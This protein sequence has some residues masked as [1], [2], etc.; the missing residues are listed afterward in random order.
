MITSLEHED[1]VI[2]YP[3]DLKQHITN[4]Y[5]KLIGYEN[6]ADIH[7]RE[8]IWSVEEKV[9]TTENERLARLFTIEEVDVALKQ[10]KNGTAPSPD[11][12]SIEFFKQF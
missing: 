6:T 8:E 2:A 10:I 5:K 3:D 9:N 12:L 7:L 1:R 4:Y 11:G